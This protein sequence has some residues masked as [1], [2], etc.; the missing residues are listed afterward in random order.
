MTACR[1]CGKPVRFYQ[2]TFEE[3]NGEKYHFECYQDIVEF[4]KWD[5][6]S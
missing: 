2:E 1:V 5:V 3:K 4:T 6:S